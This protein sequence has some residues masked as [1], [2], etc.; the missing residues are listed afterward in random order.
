[1]HPQEYQSSSNEMR[2]GPSPLIDDYRVS[3]NREAYPPQQHYPEP[4]EVKF[5]QREKRP[6]AAQAAMPGGQK[7][8]PLNQMVS[9]MI[10]SNP[11]VDV[12]ERD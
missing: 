3:T 4:E 8:R 7:K 2:L 11:L 10:K 12:E 1:M 6:D 9:D 5:S